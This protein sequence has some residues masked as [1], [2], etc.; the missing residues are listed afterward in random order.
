L[1]S[2]PVEGRI[3]CEQKVRDHTHRPD[4]HWFPMPSLEQKRPVRR[5]YTKHVRCALFLNIS[6]AIY[7]RQRRKFCQFRNRLEAD[8]L[9]PGVP[10]ISVSMLNFS[11]SITLL[12]PKSA[13]IISASSSTVRNSKFS[14]FR[15][16]QILRNRG[17][18]RKQEGQ[19]YRDG[20]SR[21]HECT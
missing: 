9:T 16:A 6:G 14:G 5:C 12:S 21:N 8:R 3:A 17:G 1:L 4:V 11:P 13:S 19:T 18:D 10:Q 15:S 7:Y 2:V 20:R